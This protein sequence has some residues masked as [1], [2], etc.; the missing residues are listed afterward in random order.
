MIFLAL[1]E[2]ETGGIFA[3]ALALVGILGK[4]LLTKKTNPYEGIVCPGMGPDMVRVLHT[5]SL[6]LSDL[7]GSCS[8]ARDH[9]KTLVDRSNREGG[10]G[11]T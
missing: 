2:I 8:D 10:H 11:G 7:K 1:S 3:I 4:L 6:A 5:M 9:L